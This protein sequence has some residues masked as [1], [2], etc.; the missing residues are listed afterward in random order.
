MELRQDY[1]ADKSMREKL[2]PLFENVFGITEDLLRKF[3]EQGF[4]DDTYCPYTYFDD[5]F[6]IAN[7]SRFDLPL[8][9]EG[10]PVSAAGIQSVMTHPDYRRQGLMK[11][12]LEIMLQD[13]DLN[14]QVSLLFTEKP[15][16]YIPFGF[17]ILPET[18]FIT[19]YEHSGQCIEECFKKLSPFMLN[20]TE[21][22]H[23][24][25]QIRIP[26]SE[27]FS[28]LRN[29]SSFFLNL[30]DLQVQER[31][32]YAIDL[33]AILVFAV[34]ADTLELYDLIS[35]NELALSD[36]CARIPSSFSRI[37]VYFN[38]DRF[39]DFDW[40]PFA[41]PSVSHLMIRGQIDFPVHL[42]YPETAKF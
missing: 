23:E 33:R 11:N 10:K 9:I 30:Y 32:Y 29:T 34:K 17:R 42:K 39:T 7:V 25:F 19:R 36:L 2:Y 35:P 16:L 13:I 22:I 5:G 40:T 14:T 38:P 41:Y 1:C 8:L 24:L 37:I 12:L 27:Q 18:C 28:P 21:L 20:N 4:W 15:E 31:L 6:A 3:H 26:Q